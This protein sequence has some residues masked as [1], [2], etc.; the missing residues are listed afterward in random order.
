MH[1]GLF[2]WNGQ[3]KK[4]TFYWIPGPSISIAEELVY[5]LINPKPWMNEKLELSTP[6]QNLNP[7]NSLPP[8]APS[9]KSATDLSR[10]R[11]QRGRKSLKETP[12]FDSLPQTDMAKRLIPTLNRVLVEKILPPSKTTSGILLPEKAP[13]VSP[14]F[15]TMCVNLRLCFTFFLFPLWGSYCS[16]WFDWSV[17]DLGKSCCGG[18]GSTG[19]SWEFDPRVC[20]GGRHCSVARFWGHPS[21]AWR[22]RVSSTY[23]FRSVSS[24][25]L[26]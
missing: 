5:H 18:T 6:I 25:P 10:T 19:Q 17:V 23:M 2:T 1:G 7:T 15:S 14:S 3:T 20:E 21:Q 12:C 16:D 13:K 8:L 22:Q 11:S 26:M 9:L 4:L 24:S